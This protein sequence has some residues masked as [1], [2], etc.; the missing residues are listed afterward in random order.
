MSQTPPIA[1]TTSVPVIPYF[2]PLQFEGGV[3]Q[4]GNLLVLHRD[5]VLPDVCVKCGAPA[6]GC[7][8]RKTYYWHHSGFY[9]LALVSIPIYAIVALCIRKR[10]TVDMGL[11]PRHRS[12]RRKAMFIGWLLCLAGL[13]C[14]IGGLVLAAGGGST[15]DDGVFVVLAGVLALLGSAFWAIFAVRLLWPQKID[16]TYAWFRGASPKFLRSLPA[17]P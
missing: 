12:W 7:R 11:C 14:M 3:W 5:A 8:L 16:D 17:T 15:A 4:E 2:S 1:P 9:V 13:A 6:E 10:I